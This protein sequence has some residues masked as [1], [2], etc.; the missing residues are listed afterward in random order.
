MSYANQT[1]GDEMSQ[2]YKVDD[3]PSKDTKE[4]TVA[5]PNGATQVFRVNTDGSRVYP[6]GSTQYWTMDQFAVA[7]D[8]MVAAGAKITETI[9]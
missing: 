6:K 2:N 1:R 4:I 8:K 9:L 3:N 5:L 7:R